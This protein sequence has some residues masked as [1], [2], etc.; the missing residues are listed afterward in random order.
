MALAHPLSVPVSAVPDLAIQWVPELSPCTASFA[1]FTSLGCYND[2]GSDEDLP[3]RSA[4][5]QYNMT[6]EDCWAIC[7]GNAFRLA[8]LTYGG[9]CYCG[10]SIQVDQVDSSY[11]D[12]SCSGDANEQCGGSGYMTIFEDTTFPDA[13]GLTINDYTP[14]GC[15]ADNLTDGRALGYP[16]DQLSGDTLT[17][18]MC[19]Q[20]CLDAGF[21][22]AGTEYASQCYCGVVQ[23]SDTYL[24]SSTSCNTPCNGNTNEIC[25]GGGA[26]S[27][28]ECKELESD[29]PCG[30]VPPPPPSSTSKPPPSSSSTSSSS[31][32]SSSHHFATN[33]FSEASVF[34]IDEHPSAPNDDIHE[35]SH[36]PNDD[37]Q[38]PNDN[39]HEHSQAPN[40]NS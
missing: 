27:M 29:Q 23:M 22:Y 26:I 2:T 18:E 15:W 12:M 14:I 20:A 10:P 7:K 25:G 13:A 36:A 38:A 17:T 11:C 31:T 3:M 5:N 8:G 9:V 39:I 34:F 32:S 33:K 1:P 28:Y 19:I 16:Q 4:A 37:I 24:I 40:D 30:Y 6:Q 21:P 35:L